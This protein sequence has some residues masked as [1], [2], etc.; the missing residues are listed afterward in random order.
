MR[1]S[2]RL[3]V[4]VML[5]FTCSAA[6]AQDVT[7]TVNRG[8]SYQT[9]RGIGGNFARGRFEGSVDVMDNDGWY[10]L[11]HMNVK[12][13]RIGIPILGWE[14]TNDNADPA[15]INLSGFAVNNEQVRN[16]FRLIQEFDRRGIPVELAVWNVPDWMITPE[17]R[18]RNSQRVLAP[19]M[20]AEL[21]ESITAFLL[22][23][24]TEYGIDN[25]DYVSTN[26]SNGGYHMILTAEEYAALV[27]MS[28]ERCRAKGFEQK[29]LVGDATTLRTVPAYLEGIMAHTE[30][31]Q[32]LGPLAYHCWGAVN[33]PDSLFRVVAGLGE[34]YGKEV[35]CEEVGNNSDW[36]GEP[37]H[38]T[39]EYAIDLAVAYQ[40][41]LGIG[42]ATVADYWEYVN[43]YSLAPGGKALPSFY[44]VKMLADNLTPGAVQVRSESGDSGVRVMAFDHAGDRRFF[45][46]L[47]NTG[48]A[49][50]TVTVKGLPAARYSLIRSSA[51]ENAV[52][53]GLHDAAGGRLRVTLPP[54][55][56]TTLVGYYPE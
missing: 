40:K 34:R 30:A 17:T 31:H 24:R 42:R 4:L 13:A 16:V 51:T 55:S 35:W 52:A 22:H 37:K 14:A 5:L 32:Y 8:T 7:L 27:V 38:D 1:T 47:I 43:D 53:D 15:A 10:N 23:A 48:T 3:M 45:L 46:Q 28:A 39:W 36:Q 11:A 41:V 26:E 56:V 21:A 29:W 44:V 50:R 2:F 9:I 49:G 33:L 25:I 20:M 6:T 12:H 54:E 18:E 19:G